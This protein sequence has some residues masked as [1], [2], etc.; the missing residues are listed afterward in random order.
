MRRMNNR[1]AAV[2]PFKKSAG[3]NLDSD[4]G[5]KHGGTGIV[6]MNLGGPETLDD[7]EPFLLRLFAD[8]EIIQLPA[9]GILGKYIAKRRTPKV[10]GL[11]AGI[12]GG[13]PILRWT[14]AQG[15]GMCTR[16]DALSPATAPHRFYVAFRYTKPFADDALL[17][18]KADGVE[19][20]IAFTQ[21][22]QWSCSTTGSSV[23]DL[24]R[25][26]SRTGLDGAFQWSIVDRW[27]E[28]PGFVH[29]MA[30][31]VREG[32][33]QYPASE[34]DDVLVLYSAHSLPL[35]VIDRGDAYPAEVAA[36]VSRVVEASGLKN[37]YLLCYQSDVGPVKWL[38]APTEGVIRGL[39]AQG[40][41]NVM[42]VPIAF[43]SDHIETLSE[44]DI[45]YAHLAQ[46]LGMT[47]FRRSPS[48]NARPDF[49]DGLASIIVDHLREGAPFSSQYTM[50]CAGCVNPACRPMLAGLAKGE[51]KSS[52]L[53]VGNA[54]HGAVPDGAAH[55]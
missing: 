44:I 13:S 10:R 51:R 6:M 17:A 35:S 23:N 45:E 18:M 9:Q 12:G 7:V 15:E 55:G 54:A 37:P 22:P 46:S 38:G 5:A 34:R 42:V 27:G 48:L 8:R 47:G 50:K 49:L 43:T 20:A 41:K 40:R 29:A 16:L 24:S 36:S 30:S 31:A 3:Q 25:A 4:N 14:R 52:S 11:Y 21:Y 39:A 2:L 19:R 53:K 1:D 26:L 32:L 33:E 28:H